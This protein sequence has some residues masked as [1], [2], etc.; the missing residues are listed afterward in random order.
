MQAEDV[1]KVASEIK[2]QLY[3]EL[4]RQSYAPNPDEFNGLVGKL[5]GIVKR[6]VEKVAPP[7]EVAKPALVAASVP[8]AIPVVAAAPKPIAGPNPPIE[9]IHI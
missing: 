6:E 7:A 4:R 8:A 1:A 3:Y 9:N 2:L 5:T